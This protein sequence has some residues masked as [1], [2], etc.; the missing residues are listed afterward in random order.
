MNIAKATKSAMGAK[1]SAAMLLQSFRR[2]LCA[3]RASLFAPDRLGMNLP[4][5]T[6]L[7]SLRE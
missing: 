2:V 5:G 1:S 3:W 4:R 6:E 7:G